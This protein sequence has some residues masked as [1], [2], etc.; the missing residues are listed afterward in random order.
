[1]FVGILLD[2]L[3]YRIH[4]EGDGWA[5]REQKVN[6]SVRSASRRQ[7]ELET[8]CVSLLFAVNF[9]YVSRHLRS[10]VIML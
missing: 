2:V 8:S 9:F 10:T 5:S 7:L 3:L 4:Q 1:V 6:R